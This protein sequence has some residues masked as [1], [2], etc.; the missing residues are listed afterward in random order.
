MLRLPSAAKGLPTAMRVAA[1]ASATTFAK[2]S[3]VK[4]S[5][6]DTRTAE[7]PIRLLIQVVGRLA[8][9]TPA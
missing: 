7:Q 8:R 5:Y 4:E 6:G 2:A 3:V 1:C 9:P